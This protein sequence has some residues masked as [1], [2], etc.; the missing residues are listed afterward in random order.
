[1]LTPAQQKQQIAD[2]ARRKAEEDAAA[3]KTIEKTR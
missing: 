2:I 1:M 3:V